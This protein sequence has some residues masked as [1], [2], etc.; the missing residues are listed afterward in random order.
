MRP[1]KSMRATRKSCIQLM[2][3]RSRVV[4]SPRLMKVKSAR[5]RGRSLTTAP[6]TRASRS[7]KGTSSLA[8]GRGYGERSAA[9]GGR[10]GLE[11]ETEGRVAEPLQGVQKLGRYG[12]VVLG[13]IGG[14]PARLIGGAS[15]LARGGGREVLRL[16]QDG[17]LDGARL[18]RALLEGGEVAP[19]VVDGVAAQLA[20][21]VV[22]LGLEWGAGGDGVADAGDGA[23][24]GAGGGVVGGVGFFEA[25]AAALGE[26]RKGGF[27]GG[28]VLLLLKGQARDERADG[29]VEGLGIVVAGDHLPERFGHR[30]DAV[31]GHRRARLAQG[32]EG[33]GHVVGRGEADGGALVAKVGFEDRRRVGGGELARDDEGVDGDLVFLALGE[34]LELVDEGL[35]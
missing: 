26:G 22:A 11:G 8:I 3:W 18:G 15:Q 13:E 12:A 16:V 31:R 6:P 28:G 27:A 10:V 32:L 33:A 34:V 30:L 24:H 35:A 23:E 14:Q 4:V 2:R 7:T 17:F 5:G 9:A 20:A 29:G 25:L 21:G 19:D 1:S